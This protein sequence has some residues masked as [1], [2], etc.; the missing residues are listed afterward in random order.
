MR[1][2]AGDS[3]CWCTDL[4]RDLFRIEE[5]FLS[6]PDTQKIRPD[7][8]SDRIARLLLAENLRTREEL[9]RL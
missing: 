8:V 4:R 2:S 7:E 9:Q 6:E 3:V 5:I 1:S